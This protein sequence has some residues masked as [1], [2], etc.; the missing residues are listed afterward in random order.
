MNCYISKTL[1]A[2]KKK[3]ANLTE[4]FVSPLKETKPSSMERSPYKPLS[5]I[6]QNNDS[7]ILKKSLS[8]IKGSTL[9]AIANLDKPS[10]SIIN[11]MIAFSSIMQGVESIRW[12]KEC[13]KLKSIEKTY[14]NCVEIFKNPEEILKLANELIDNITV[15]QAHR[16][17]GIKEKYLAGSDM[18]PNLISSKYLAARK[19]LKF[20]DDLFCFVE[21]LF[22]YD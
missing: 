3:I 6:T 21:V 19:L 11:L 10:Q 8:E 12:K 14:N 17:I 4:F 9:K 7:I 13:D 1:K 5:I 22:R 16:I 20:L 15:S 2:S 18:K